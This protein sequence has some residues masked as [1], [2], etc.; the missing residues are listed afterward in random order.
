MAKAPIGLDYNQFANYLEAVK[1]VNVHSFKNGD[2][3]W[4]EKGAFK[5]SKYSQAIEYEYKKNDND[6]LTQYRTWYMETSIVQEKMGLIVSAKIDHIRG[7]G[8]KDDHIILI[9]AFDQ[10]ATLIVAQASVQITSDSQYNHTVAPKTLTDAGGDSMQ[11]D[12]LVYNELHKINFN[13]FGRNTIAD[14]V[15]ANIIALRESVKTA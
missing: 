13:D 6:D 15:K 11:I 7:G 5:D 12:N 3:G 1:G 9:C 8:G 2:Y 14:V 4:F 10:N